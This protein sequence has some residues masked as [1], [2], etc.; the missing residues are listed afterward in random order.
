[1]SLSFRLGMELATDES[2]V[3]HDATIDQLP[4][5]LDGWYYPV[6]GE[7]RILNDLSISLAE[8]LD[9]LQTDVDDIQFLKAR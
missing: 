5:H 7:Q 2:T 3:I 6:D 8:S 4:S 1:L 9:Q